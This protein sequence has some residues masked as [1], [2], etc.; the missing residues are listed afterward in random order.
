MFLQI[1][2]ILSSNRSST[3]PNVLWQETTKNNASQLDTRH[4]P[5]SL[6]PLERF[7]SSASLTCFRA[8][9]SIYNTDISDQGDYELVV[10]NSKGIMESVVELKVNMILYS[11]EII[12]KLIIKLNLK[13]S[14]PASISAPVMKPIGHIILIMLFALTL[15]H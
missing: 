14:S 12:D 8:I 5:R 1:I 7:T 2:N 10:Q 6:I 4:K 15:V 9:L 3:Y 11:T 13:V